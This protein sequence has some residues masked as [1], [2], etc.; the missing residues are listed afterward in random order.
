MASN[1]VELI[2]VEYKTAKYIHYKSTQ[3]WVCRYPHP[4]Q[5]LHDKR[6]EFIGK[7]FQWLLEIFSIKDVCSTS[8]NPQFNAICERIHQTVNNVLT[9]LVHTNPPCNMTQAS[10]ITDDALA[11]TMHAM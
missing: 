4:V 8:K 1:L 3:N 6:G 7:N 11:T 2:R 9:T 10:A 5:C